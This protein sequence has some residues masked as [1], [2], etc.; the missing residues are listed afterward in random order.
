L[1]KPFIGIVLLALGIRIFL[2]FF[3]KKRVELVRGEFSWRFLLLLGFI[4][5]SVNSFGG[6]E[7][8]PICT[9]TLVSTNKTEPRYVCWFRKSR[10][11]FHYTGDVFTFG[12]TLGFE[13]FLWNITIPLI[14]GGVIAAPLAAYTCK[15]CLHAFWT[16]W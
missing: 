12:G 10:G 15:K 13:N 9:S 11:D 7:W 8:G 3:L 4:G 16:P 5:G 6:G 2:R 14:I 1:V